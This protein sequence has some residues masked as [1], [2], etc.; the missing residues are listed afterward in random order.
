MSW[1][2]GI[3]LLGDAAR[4]LSILI[5]A[6]GVTI[7]MFTHADVAALTVAAGCFGAL[8]GA[9]SFENHTQIKADADVKKSNGGSNGSGTNQGPV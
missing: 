8:V 4:P 6:L 2:R 9:R 5:F 7:G 1:E 3:A